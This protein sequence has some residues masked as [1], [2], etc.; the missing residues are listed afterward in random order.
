MKP[1][2][3]TALIFLAPLGVGLGLFWLGAIYQSIYVITSYGLNMPYEIWVRLALVLVSA[4]IV[5]PVLAW[6]FTRKIKEAI[7]RD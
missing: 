3:K 1:K 7:K 4:G 2:T 6:M 5:F